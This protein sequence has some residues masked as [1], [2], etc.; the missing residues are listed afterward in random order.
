MSTEIKSFYQKTNQAKMQLLSRLEQHQDVVNAAAII[1]GHDGVISVSEDKFG[2][3]VI[4]ALTGLQ[5]LMF[6]LV[7]HENSLYLY[8]LTK[9]L[10]VG[11]ENGYISEFSLSEDFNRIKLIKNYAAHQNKI[12]ALLFSLDTE[13]LLSIGRDKYFIWH[14]SERGQ[15][16]GAYFCQHICT[17]L[18]FD[19]QSKNAFIGDSNGHIEMIKLENN[20]YKPI[21]TLKGHLASVRCLAWDS[22]NQLLFSGGADKVIICWDIGGKK[23]TVYELQGH[24]NAITSLY[25]SNINRQ[26]ISSSEDYM[27]ITWDMSCQRKETP[28]WIESDFCQRCQRPFFWNIK[29]MYNQKT[30]GYRQHHCRLCGKAICDDCSSNRS[31]LPRYG[32]EFPVRVCNDCFV[33]ITEADRVS[34]AKFYDSKH[35]ITHMNI[36]E[37]HQL[38]VTSGFDRVIK[39]WDISGLFNNGS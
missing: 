29:A 5:C 7:C 9:R 31:T 25:F 14:C 6:F 21:T 1:P 3:N 19:H 10:F 36:D 17:A 18:Q 20:T 30:L 2:S 12:K 13:W 33:T 22:V 16:L 27:I 24:Q 23:G 35:C 39:L 34:L 38:M 28:E 37:A 11:L 15:R 32:Y 8:K 26:L 4:Q